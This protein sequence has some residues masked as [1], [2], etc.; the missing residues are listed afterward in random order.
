MTDPILAPLAP[1]KR[2]LYGPGPSMVE[3]RVYQAMAQPV[4]GHLDE[5]FFQV[6]EDVKRLLQMVFETENSFT[7]AMSATG[8]GGMETAVTNFTRPGDKFAIFANGFFCDRMTEMAK[9][10]G[11]NVVR[12]EKPWGET[13]TDD[14]ARDFIKREKPALVGYVTAETS[15]GAW[16]DGTA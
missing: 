11:A 1:P 4:V 3:P 7:M 9:R 13:F 14:E 10:H 8:S 5:Y 15:T 6:L 2:L 16:Q 12:F